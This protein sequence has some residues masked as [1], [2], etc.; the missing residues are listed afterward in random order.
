MSIKTQAGPMENMTTTRQHYQAYEPAASKRHYGELIPN[1]Y[2]PP[3]S[4][5]TGTT[6]TGDTYQ[7]KTGEI[8]VHRI[9]YCM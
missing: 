6:T 8:R 4:K 1:I 3:L 9:H 7:G 5:F 2:I